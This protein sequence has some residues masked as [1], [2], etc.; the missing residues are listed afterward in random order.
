VIAGAARRLR[1]ARAG[2]QKRPSRRCI[3]AIAIGAVVGEGALLWRATSR[4]GGNVI[5]RCRDGHLFTTIWIPGA[6][7]KAFRLGRWRYQRC[8]VGNHW[9][10]VT[11][12]RESELTDEEHELAHSRRDIRL[13]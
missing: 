10:L 13:P 7:V 12:V 2:R 9:S 1:P 3:A 11:P 4:V 6:S 5:V 8:P